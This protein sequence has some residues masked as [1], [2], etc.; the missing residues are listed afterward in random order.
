MERYQVILAYDGTNFQGYQIQPDARTVQG[1]F[2]AALRMLGW[3][4]KSIL[5][6]G[7]TDTGVHASGQVVAFDL[8]W[9]H[10]VSDLLRALNDNLPSDVAVREVT[11]VPDDFHPRRAA[12]ARRYQYRLFCDPIRDPLRERYAWRIW[13]QVFMEPLEPALKYLKGNHDF[14]AFGAPHRP[15]GSTVREISGASWHSDR[16]DLVF[17]IIGNAFLYHM[18]RRLVFVLAKIGQGDLH[19]EIL[20]DLLNNPEQP[21][22]HGLAPSQGLFLTEVIFP[23]GGI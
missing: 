23:S 14:A 12:L 20:L 7:R 13:P 19:P 21:R 3:Q 11:L 18:V 17:E 15:G 9:A 1:V 4:D 5:A 6:A 22:I 16:T 10:T 2:E 8:Q